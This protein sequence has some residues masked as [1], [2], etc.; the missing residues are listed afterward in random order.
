M[1]T[2]ASHALVFGA[3]GITGWAILKEALNYPSSDTFDRVIGLTKRPL[4]KAE[5]SLP[6]DQRLV[7]YSGIDLADKPES[8]VEGLK[9]VEGID[10]VTHVFFAGSNQ[11]IYVKLLLLLTALKHMCS[12]KGR[13]I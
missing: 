12:Q 5:A 1:A 8:I 3:S 2:K 7:L 11:T 9:K 10:D 4:T 6:D 13:Q